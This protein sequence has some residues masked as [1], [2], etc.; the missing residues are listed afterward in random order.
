M[1]RLNHAD[2]P[3]SSAEIREQELLEF[4]ELMDKLCGLM[5]RHY[6][7]LGVT[8]ATPTPDAIAN[9]YEFI[10]AVVLERAAPQ[11]I[12]AN[13]RA[14]LSMSAIRYVD[15]FL[16]DMLWPRLPEI[17]QSTPNELIRKQ[18]TD[19]MDSAEQI[20]RE[21]DPYFPPEIKALPL[22]ELELTLSPTQET[23]NAYTDDYVDKKSYNISYLRHL[24]LRDQSQ[25]QELWTP[26]Q[27]NEN[28]LLAIWDIA[29]D[30]QPVQWDKKDFNIFRHI[31][32][33]ELEPTVLIAR[34]Q[35]AL[36]QKLP[37]VYA[38]LEQYFFDLR[39]Y[40][41]NAALKE[42]L[43]QAHLSLRENYFVESAMNALYTL[44]NLPASEWIPG[45]EEGQPTNTD[46][47]HDL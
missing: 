29:R 11:E 4:R 20:I 26:Q 33:H 1:P 6:P 41:C 9:N 14:F 45:H 16:D 32:T 42:P 35:S 31:S 21:Y 30:L 22:I 15:D 3:R 28:E 23:L 27:K 43:Q 34:I 39:S 40:E 37:E 10:S 46:S 47:S 19:F 13:D 17:I 5:R 18:L 38:V 12:H 24:L 2:I 7:T 36:K 44:T 8:A 25:T